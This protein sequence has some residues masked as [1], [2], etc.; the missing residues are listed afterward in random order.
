MAVLGLAFSRRK[1]PV[2][3]NP[4]IEA[5]TKARLAQRLHSVDRSRRLREFGA[6]RGANRVHERAYAYRVASA[7]LSPEEVASCRVVNQSHSGMRLSFNSD[8]QCPDEFGLTIPTLGFVGIVR[9]VW[10]NG[11][12]TGVAI[13]RWNDAE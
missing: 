12:D 3:N 8:I 4:D 13:V 5:E 6:I 10:Q 9:K 7:I 2:V 11:R 1:A